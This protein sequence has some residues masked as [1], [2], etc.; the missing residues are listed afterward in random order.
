MNGIVSVEANGEVSI[1]GLPNFPII[2]ENEIVE[3]IEKENISSIYE[4]CKTDK[5]C[6]TCKFEDAKKVLIVTTSDEG[7]KFAKSCNMED[8]ED[9]EPIAKM[10]ND[11]SIL[12]MSICE[13]DWRKI[14]SHNGIKS[15][16]ED[17]E[18]EPYE[19]DREKSSISKILSATCNLTC[20]S[21]DRINVMVSSINDEGYEFAKSC[22]DETSLLEIDMADGPPIVVG[23]ICN[24]SWNVIEDHTGVKNIEVDNNVNILNRLWLSILLV[25][26]LS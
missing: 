4:D 26:V 13:E 16:E 24:E 12:S 3:E 9:A 25:V 20:S 14:V 8:R 7:I 2:E 10:N 22:I 19:S 18:V 17:F 1:P 5:C 23:A 15:V 6:S 21:G 11:E